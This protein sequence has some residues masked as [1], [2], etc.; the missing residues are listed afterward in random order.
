MP[1]SPPTL[2]SK[3]FLCIED[4]VAFTMHISENLS[5]KNFNIHVYDYVYC[6]YLH[7]TNALYT[8]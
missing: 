7:C 5:S 3:T 4:M 8:V 1:I 6:A 2:I